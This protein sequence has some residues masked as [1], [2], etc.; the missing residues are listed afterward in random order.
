MD[1]LGENFLFFS[2]LGFMNLEGILVPKERP[3]PQTYPSPL[4]LLLRNLKLFITRK[5]QARNAVILFISV[6]HLN[7]QQNLELLSPIG[8][9]RSLFGI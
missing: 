2:T 1:G 8:V 9:V 4:Y 5:Q 6:I 3:L 7:G